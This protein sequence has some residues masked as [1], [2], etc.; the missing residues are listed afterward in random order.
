MWWRLEVK[1]MVKARRVSFWYGAWKARGADHDGRVPFSP[2]AAV[3][4]Q[5]RRNSMNPMF[6]RD[7]NTPIVLSS[8]ELLG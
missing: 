1:A 6:W 7:G 2:R 3:S 5:S 4:D 8:V